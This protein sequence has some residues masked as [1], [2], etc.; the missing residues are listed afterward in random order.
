MKARFV[1]TPCTN[2]EKCLAIRMEGDV[3]HL[4]RETVVSKMHN[5]VP[6]QV[7]RL[8]EISRLVVTCMGD[9]SGSAV[10]M[11]LRRL[12]KGMS[13][14]EFDAIHGFAPGTTARWEAQCGINS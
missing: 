2:C 3:V 11:K 10:R 9:D 12:S 13:H 6:G 14:S 4:A 5:F 1:A 7:I 8:A